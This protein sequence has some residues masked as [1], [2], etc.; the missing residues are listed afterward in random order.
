MSVQLS[1]LPFEMIHIAQVGETL[2]SIT[3]IYG[4]TYQK[5]A[6]RND[7]TSPYTIYANQGIVVTIPT[8][9]VKAKETW[10]GIGKLHGI[11]YEVLA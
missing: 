8:H 9:T 3:K 5:I 2:S 1:L 4:T 7:I 11:K 6:D 10:Y